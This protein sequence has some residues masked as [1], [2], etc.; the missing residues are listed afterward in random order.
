VKD[1]FSTR[2][3]PVR[4]TGQAAGSADDCGRRFGAG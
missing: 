4:G 1:L 3:D 2:S